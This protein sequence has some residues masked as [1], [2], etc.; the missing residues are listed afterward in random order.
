MRNLTTETDPSYDRD[1]IFRENGPLDPNFISDAVRTLLRNLPIEETAEPAGWTHRR[2][3]STMTAL[4]AL[5][6]RD[7]IEIMLS[8]QALSAY[9]AAAV[10]WRLGMNVRHPRGDS[11][12]H[13][14]AAASAARTFDT[15]IKAIERR[16]AKPLAIPAGRPPSRP[17]Q[18]TDPAEFVRE[19]R[20]RCSRGENDPAIGHPGPP[21]PPVIWTKEDMAIVEELRE[22][23][24]IEEETKGLDIANTEGI[25]PDGSIIM[26]EYPT[27]QQDAYIARRINLMY[28][29]ERKENLRNGNK[30]KTVF[31][32]LRTGDL[33]P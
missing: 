13:I 21:G 30:V 10:C 7:E 26:P 15:M 16:Q 33:V 1:A 27:P 25:R 5:H 12:R 23:E 18:E 14:T 32:P 2:M 6:P 28:I 19:W 24:R 29:R 8:V 20:E 22:R 3:Q 9:H 17:W 31:R 4:S 11:T